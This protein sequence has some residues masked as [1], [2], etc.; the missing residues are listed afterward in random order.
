M[1]NLFQKETGDVF[2]EK[3]IQ[4]QQEILNRHCLLE[5]LSILSP[6]EGMAQSN[7]FCL[8]QWSTKLCP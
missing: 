8:L 3:D 5:K 2:S 1:R 7:R 4:H 6:K